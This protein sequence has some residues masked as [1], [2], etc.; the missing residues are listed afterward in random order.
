MAELDAE[1]V[2]RVAR[3]CAEAGRQAG[4]AEI[5]RALAPLTWDQLLLVMS[6]LADP[7]PA[8]PLGPHALADLAR[9]APPDL[10]AE[11][12]R[13]GRYRSAGE[14]EPEPPPAPPA[15]EVAAV[16][17]A[18]GRPRKRK[19]PGVVIRRARDR[20]A[21]EPQAPP[22][23]PALDELRRPEGRTV[24]ERLVRRH[25]ARRTALARA[26]AAGWRRPDG[27]APDEDDVAA[28]L[29]HHGLAHSFEHR[30]R[31]EILH[32]IRAAGGAHAAAAARLGMEPGALVAALARL[33]ATGEAE[34]IREQR[35]RELRSRG[36]ISQRV[37]LLF[38]DEARLVD[39]GLLAEFEEDLRARLPE[40]IRALRTGREPMILAL[41]RSL[42]LADAQASALAVRFGLELVGTRA[43]SRRERAPGAVGPRPARADGGAAPPRPS[44]GGRPPRAQGGASASRTTGRGRPPRAQGGAGAPRT[45]GRGRPAQAKGRGPP[46]TSSGGRPPA[47]QGG[48]RPRPSGA[49]RRRPGPAE[50]RGGRRR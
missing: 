10:A 39:L 25:G 3:W 17:A 20:A 32:A 18:R 36:T 44:G 12:E 15:R 47:T 50:P 2:E 11:R 33:G 40:H 28:L 42:S 8:R 9:G 29:D 1:V 19:G 13:E 48:A 21:S 35:R 49:G 27:G 34:R 41:A 7:P 46:R 30:E 24:L 31:D 43:P 14:A 26:L 45:T 22:T 5:R 6:V 37:R 16:A 4:A 38:S 23:L